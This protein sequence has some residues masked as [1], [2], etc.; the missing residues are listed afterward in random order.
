MFPRRSKIKAVRAVL[1]L[2]FSKVFLNS[3]KDVGENF[4]NWT[5]KIPDPSMREKIVGSTP[6]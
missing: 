5:Y 2:Y 3:S 6:F 4:L 1:S